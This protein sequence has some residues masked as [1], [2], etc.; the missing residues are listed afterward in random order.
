MPEVE[1]YR[2]KIEAIKERLEKSNGK[3][4]I[5]VREL[6]ERLGTVRDSLRRKQETIDSQ[7]VEIAA[8]REESAQLS[9]M[10]GQALGALE[11]QSQGGIKEIVQSIDAEFA[12]LL[13]DNNAQPE[14][15]GTG[16]DG[17]RREPATAEADSQEAE[18]QDTPS[19]E[20]KW[21]PENESAPALQRILGRR[22]H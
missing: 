4:D 9:D 18:S 17:G 21:D 2:I 11:T 10:L 12:D 6:K 15:D 22:K 1:E 19:E 7:K 14:Q 5:E 13:A 3:G 16:G 20:P 8:L